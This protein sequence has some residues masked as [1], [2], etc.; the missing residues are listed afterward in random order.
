MHAAVVT[1]FG[2]PPRYLEFAD[3]KLASGEVLVR[4]HAAGLH[5][6][7]RSGAAGTHYTSNNTLPLVPGVDGVGSTLDGR[8]VYFGDLAAPHGSFA[9]WLV[10]PIQR[11]IPI[12]D[13]PS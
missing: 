8:R 11:L 7:V 3:P 12:P 5:P 10:L 2:K 9:E 4:V 1:E 6:R 13:G